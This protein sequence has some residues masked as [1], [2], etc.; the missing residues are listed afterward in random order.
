MPTLHEVLKEKV[1]VKRER[2]AEL[3]KNYGD[4]VVSQVTVSPGPRWGAGSK[5]APVQHVS[6]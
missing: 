1:L 4:V 3:N 6:S 2:I 5:I